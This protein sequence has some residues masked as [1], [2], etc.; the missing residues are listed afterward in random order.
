MIPLTFICCLL[1]VTSIFG[2]PCSHTDGTTVLS[3]FSGSDSTASCNCGTTTC[4]KSNSHHFCKVSST[5][6]GSC[7]SRPV[8]SNT[9][10]TQILTQ[11][12]TGVFG[13]TKCQCG[14]TRCSFEEGITSGGVTHK[15]WYVP[16]LLFS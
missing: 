9:D 16:C 5:N 7:S 4:Y 1:L 13:N 3:I 8:C 15:Y 11:P 12:T 10:G 2:A 14:S 6:T